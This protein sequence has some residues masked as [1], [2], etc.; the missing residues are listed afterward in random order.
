MTESALLG[1]L[2]DLADGGLAVLDP[3]RGVVQAANPAAGRLLG[4]TALVG[5]GALRLLAGPG[6]GPRLEACR[7]ALEREAEGSWPLELRRRD[8]R[9][10]RVELAYRLVELDGSHR[11]LLSVRQGALLQRLSRELQQNRL[12]LAEVQRLGRIGSW[13]YRHR[14]ERLEWSQEMGEIFRL[15]AERWPTTL[16]AMRQLVHPLDRDRVEA[17]TLQAQRRG[18][19]WE[20]HYRITTGVGTAQL[21]ERGESR[22]DGEGRP[23]LSH[24]TVQELGDLESLRRE[25][26]HSS[27][28]DDLTGLPNRPA[29]IRRIAQLL[30]ERPQ[31]YL[32]AVLDIDVD[33]FQAINESFG[34]GVGNRLLTTLADRL[35]LA[36][37][38][39]DLA[40][41]I[42][43]DEF[44]VVRG[45]IQSVGEARALAQELQQL[46]GTVH[47]LEPQIRVHAPVSVGV[48]VGPLHSG[49]PSELVQC[50]NTALTSAKQ[51][52]RQQLE[53]YGSQLSRRILERLEMEQELARAIDRHQLQLHYQPQVNGEGL[54]MGAEALLRWRNNR[55]ESIPPASFI[56][57]AETSGLIVG[58]GA[59]VVQEAFRQLAE[60]RRRG[61]RLPQLALNLSPRQ[62]GTEGQLLEL[63][64]EASQCHGVEPGAVEF[65]L[66]E[67]GI[68]GEVGP[69]KRQ[70]EALAARG[71]QLAIDDFGTGYSSLGMLHQ[72]PLHTLK[73]DRCFVQEMERQGTGRSLVGATVAM[74]GQLGLSTVAEGVE[75][76]EQ[77]ALLRQLGCARFQGY[78]FAPP[79]P[80]SQLEEL[81]RRGGE[82]QRPC[83]LSAAAER[84]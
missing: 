4:R 58:I 82:A 66:T 62:F 12:L 49:D 46:L 34:M 24:G 22:C 31:P 39:G 68:Q 79:L 8:G 21:L 75:T 3:D 35:S 27:H 72:L 28:H 14:P 80:V 83:A 9:P 67:S 23:L 43:S 37:A 74:A 76:A 20:V 47:R 2:L 73:I 26:E 5:M 13:D 16:A 7:R 36:L 6:R 48:S 25:L 70:L 60:W 55:G 42:G 41:R 84:C 1:A 54:L 64:D 44:L 19:A 45:G 53:V 57:L 63:I 71:Y 50:A 10:L 18:E 69:V 81:M 78:L 33:G 40:G 17:A 38:P 56:P 15:P 52:G 29:C 77:L 11:L 51:R 32:V 59:W 30:R 61:L 65:E